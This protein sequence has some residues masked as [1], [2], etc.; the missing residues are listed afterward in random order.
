MKNFIRLFLR[1]MPVN[2]NSNIFA[3]LRGKTKSI[4][5]IVLIDLKTYVK[6]K[7]VFVRKPELKF[8]VYG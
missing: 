6:V 4:I 7:S 2:I 1:L 8:Q 3:G 5:I